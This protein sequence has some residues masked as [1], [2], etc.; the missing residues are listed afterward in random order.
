MQMLC[1][2]S[3]GINTELKRMHFVH[4]AIPDLSLDRIRTD[5][6]IGKAKLKS[7]ILLLA[8]SEDDARHIVKREK[9]LPVAFLEGESIHVLI[10][11]GKEVLLAKGM[12][13]ARAADGLAAAKILRYGTNIMPYIPKDAARNAEIYVKQLKMAMFLTN[14]ESIDRMR[15]ASIYIVR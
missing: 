6:T 8:E 7:P 14:S 5:F 1:M 4:C 10:E 2:N 15:T 12:Y 13:L 9:V 3:E 11:G